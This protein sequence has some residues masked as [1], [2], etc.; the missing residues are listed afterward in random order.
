MWHSLCIAQASIISFITPQSRV[1]HLR[2]LCMTA[3]PT[4]IGAWLHYM[5][6]TYSNVHQ[7]LMMIIIRGAHNLQSC[8]H[9][10]QYQQ[11]MLQPCTCTSHGHANKHPFDVYIHTSNKD[12][13]WYM[14][15]CA[16]T[17]AKCICMCKL[18]YVYKPYTTVQHTRAHKTRCHTHMTVWA[19][20][21]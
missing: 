5:I 11:F 15:T 9:S 16:E 17:A 8:T 14:K 10:D 19:Y 13:S 18:T 4:F 21:E 7:T 2:W 12:I 6:A 3:T 1:C 20:A